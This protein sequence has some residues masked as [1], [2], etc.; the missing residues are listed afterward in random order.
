MIEGSPSLPGGLVVEPSLYTV[1]ASKSQ[2]ADQLSSLGNQLPIQVRN[3]S[4]K[5]IQIP[6]K[7]PLAT[8]HQVEVM[9]SLDAMDSDAEDPPEDTGESISRQEFFKLFKL[10]GREDEKVLD[11]LYQWKNV[12]SWN[13]FDLGRTDL[14]EHRIELTDETPIRLPHRRIPPNLY[15][16]VKQHLEQMEKSGAIRASKSPW[17][18]PT[19]LVRKKS[20]ELR[21]CVDYRALNSRTVRD[22]YQLP[23]IDEAMD[24]LIGAKYFST[25]DLK[26]GYWQV[27]V[28]KE[29]KERTAQLAH[30]D[31][32][33]AIL[34]H[35]DCAM[36]PQHFSD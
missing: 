15:E 5:A 3:S 32:G 9:S 20:G 21:F 13:D 17:A 7:A 25:L 18:F 12:F 31:S 26:S 33:N 8:L 28:A 30:W 36:H 35:L 1:D 6:K 29:H 22:A 34:C 16:E 19:V 2:L 27:Q 10:S 23:R 14:F 24:A 4:S 11:L